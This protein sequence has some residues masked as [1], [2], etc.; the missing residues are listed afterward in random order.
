M[1]RLIAR[2]Y[3]SKNRF[4]CYD[5]KLLNLYSSDLAE[6]VKG[7]LCEKHSSSSYTGCKAR[8][9]IGKNVFVLFDWKS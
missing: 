9:A 8:E 5:E 3:V 4:E 7:N 6:M 1:L 2:D